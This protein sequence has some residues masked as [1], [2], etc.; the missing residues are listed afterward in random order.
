MSDTPRQTEH[1]RRVEQELEAQT[2]EPV[3]PES[4]G[5]AN[6][7]TGDAGAQDYEEEVEAEQEG[8][9]AEQDERDE[10]PPAY[11]RRSG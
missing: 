7:Y 10:A 6:R 2:G 8:R 9:T 11:R 3:S 1:E 5:S 4:G